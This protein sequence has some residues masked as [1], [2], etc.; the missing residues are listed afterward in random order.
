MHTQPLQLWSVARRASVLVV[1][2][3]VVL[4]SG[5]GALVAAPV[6][7]GGKP[8]QTTQSGGQPAQPAK[9]AAPAQPAPVSVINTRP[10]VVAPTNP[11]AVRWGFYVTYNPNSLV[12]LRAHVDQLNYVSPWFYSVTG[13]GNI[14]NSV[15]P[16]VNTLLASKGVHNL[17]MLKNLSSYANFHDALANPAKRALIIAAMHTVVQANNYDGITIDFEGLNADDRSLL[18]NFMYELY[19]DF[20]GMNKLVA[21][22]VPPKTREVTTGWAGPFDYPQLAH[23]TDY[24]IL[25]A[26]DQHYATGAPGPIAP[27]GWI[28]DVLRYAQQTVDAKKLVLGIGLYGYDWNTSTHAQADPRTW[29]EVQALA[30]RFGGQLG[31]SAPDASPSLL[32]RDFT[33]NQSHEVWYENQQSFDAKL[34]LVRSSS[35]AGFALWRLG[36]EDPGVWNSITRLQSPCDPVAPFVSTRYVWYVRETGHSLQG[37]FLNYWNTH[38]GAAIFGYPLTEEFVEVSAIDGR[39]YTVQYFERNRFEYH[40]E[41]RGTAYEVQLGLLG[42]QVL[43][44]RFFPVPPSHIASAD[45]IFFAQTG[46]LLGGGFRTY[47]L[48]HGGLPLFGYPL[49]EEFT[50]RNS[51]DGNYY[52]VQYFERARF[53]W[54]PELRGTPFEFQLGL[55]GKRALAVRGCGP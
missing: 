30:Q 3:L 27:I 21:M 29:G 33:Q 28:G 8:P 42:V 31:W 14:T 10:A 17:P 51:D 20:K 40:P 48:S 35:I 25:M 32:Y 50:E 19:S 23:W 15:Q 47:W 12:S 55:L 53:E 1:V 43:Q 24:L 9:P 39:A 41:A 22:A 5:S 18:T 49:T 52:T 6:A 16:D 4:S 34:A 36:Q 44:N 54:H 7:P 38:G 46:H 26:Y 45:T 2:A 11:L 13:D 37:A